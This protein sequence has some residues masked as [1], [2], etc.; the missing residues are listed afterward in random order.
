MN[1]KSYRA[2]L[3]SSMIC[4]NGTGKVINRT[5]VKSVAC[6]YD[7]AVDMGWLW[8]EHAGSPVSKNIP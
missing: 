7:Y 2:A 4:D 8:G 5:Y 1:K 3:G 6:T